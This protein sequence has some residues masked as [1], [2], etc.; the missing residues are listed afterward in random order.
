M[1]E[2]IQSVNKSGE[3]ITDLQ[4][5]LQG[6]YLHSWLVAGPVK[7]PVLDLGNYRGTD[8]KAQIARAYCRQPSVNQLNPAEAR[9]FEVEDPS[10]AKHALVWQTVHCGDDH[11][12]NLTGF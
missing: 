11:Y 8:F 5:N 1:N 7:T 10:G 12:V 4:Y 6:G 9:T 2:Q 3:E